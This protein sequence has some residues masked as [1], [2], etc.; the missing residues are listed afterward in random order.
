MGE[1][2]TV[3][4]GMSKAVKDAI[5]SGVTS[6]QGGVTDGVTAVLP[7]AMAIIALTMGIR[8]CINFFK[9]VAH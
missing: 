9:G 3:A 2:A 5:T 1:T 7:G 4:S 8:I 6:V